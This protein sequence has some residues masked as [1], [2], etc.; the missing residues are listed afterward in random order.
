[1]KETGFTKNQLVRLY[2]R[3]QR[4][5]RDNDGVLRREDFLRIPE[6]VINPLGDRIVNAF[7][8]RPF[9]KQ[10][11]FAGGSANNVAQRGTD[12][13]PNNDHANNVIADNQSG[14]GDD[15]EEVD[16]KKFVRVLAV[17]R[18]VKTNRRPVLN[19]REDKLRFAF[20][21]YDLDEDDKM[22]RE[23][24]LSVLRELVGEHVP[25][26]QLQNIAHRTIEEND[27]DLDGA[28]SFREFCDCLQETDIVERLSLRFLD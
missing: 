27:K 14:N 12:N 18:P 8:R 9:E 3:F 11:Q 19:S 15:D 2:S 1:M 5:D 4:M 16:F 22:S 6:L 24:L 7:F 21:I 20:Q 17:F 23:E 10:Q 13:F 25:E 28:I 26:E